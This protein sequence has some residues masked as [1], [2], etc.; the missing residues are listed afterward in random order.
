MPRVVLTFLL[1]SATSLAQIDA[2][3]AEIRAAYAVDPSKPGSEL[4]RA[5]DLFEVVK[6]KPNRATYVDALRM[7]LE[8]R[9]NSARMRAD[10]CARLLYL[11]DTREDLQLAARVLARVNF[12]EVG[13]VPFYALASGVARKNADISPAAFQLLEQPDLSMRFVADFAFDQAALVASLLLPIDQK[14]W[15]DSAIERL[16]S[17][18]DETAQRTLLSLLWFAQTDF[19]DDELAAFVKDDQKPVSSRVLAAELLGR[20]PN[21]SVLD[22]TEVLAASEEE[23]RER[24]RTRQA[25]GVY[26]KDLMATIHRDTMKILLKRRLAAS[27][28]PPSRR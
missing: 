17:E 15:A 10:G 19:A 1:F 2:V 8:D 22:R 9:S 25:A 13:V 14:Y 11:S 24:R 23:L 5:R 20:Q 28:D 6:T 3:R 4:L 26:F 7:E 16:S 18:Q 27:D 12:R 21:V